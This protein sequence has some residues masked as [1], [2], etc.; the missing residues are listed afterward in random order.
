MA[1]QQPKLAPQRCFVGPG[2]Y[3]GPQLAQ[4]QPVLGRTC[5]RPD[6]GA[7]ALVGPQLAPHGIFVDRPSQWAKLASRRPHLGRSFERQKLAS[8]RPHLVWPPSGHHLAAGSLLRPQLAP[9]GPL[10]ARTYFGPKLAPPALLRPQ[11]AP[12]RLVLAINAAASR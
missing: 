5:R 2:P 11:L 7:A 12:D 3:G 8:S 9:V 10:L 4:Q 6:L 1:L